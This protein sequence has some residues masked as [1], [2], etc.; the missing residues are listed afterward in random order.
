M[1][2]YDCQ[3]WEVG[4]QSVQIDGTRVVQLDAHTTWGTCPQSIGPSMEEGRNAQLLN[5]LHQGI[6]SRVIWIEGLYTG[7][8]FC[9]CQ[10][11]I[12]DGALHFLHSRFPFMGVHTRETNELL[13][14]ALYDGSD[15]IVSQRREASSSF[16]IPCQQDT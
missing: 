8:K 12:F 1:G 11:Q 14:V 15:I 16:R 5:F 9:A 13:W 2:S 6:E 3:P 7:V 10:A 4:C